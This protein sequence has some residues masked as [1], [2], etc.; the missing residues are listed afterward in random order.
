MGNYY[1]TC[2]PTGEETKVEYTFGYTR[3]HVYAYG[4][5]EWWRKMRTLS[6]VQRW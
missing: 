4:T 3:S 6:S 5:D 1:F 2:A